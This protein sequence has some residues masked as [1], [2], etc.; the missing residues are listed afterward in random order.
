MAQD[1]IPFLG[2]QDKI[3]ILG[4]IQLAQDKI[5]QLRTTSD[6]D[7]DWLAQDKIGYLRTTSDHD[8]DWLAQDKFGYLRMTSDPK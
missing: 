6:S 5:G 1:K 2:S 7:Q 3:V 8:Q 4:Q